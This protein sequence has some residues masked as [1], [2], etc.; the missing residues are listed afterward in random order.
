[1]HTQLEGIELHVAIFLPPIIYYP[2]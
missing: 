1:M 2:L